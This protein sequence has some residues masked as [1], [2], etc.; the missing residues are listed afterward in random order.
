MSSGCCAAQTLAATAPA[1]APRAVRVRSMAM[2][3]TVT[4]VPLL[5]YLP[6]PMENRHLTRT[7]DKGV[8]PFAYWI[9][10]ALFQPFF[11]LYFRMSRIGRE[12]IPAEG[13]VIFAANH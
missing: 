3:V 7:R 10:R 5:V 11:H 6:I 1:S 9:V 8:N 4:P 13:P 2:A 12:H